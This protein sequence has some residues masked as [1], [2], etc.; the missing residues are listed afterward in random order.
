MTEQ[1]QRR[2]DAARWLALCHKRADANPHTYPSDAAADLAAEAR[3]EGAE[4]ERV[5]SAG[6]DI[7]AFQHAAAVLRD[8]WARAAVESVA[9]CIDALSDPKCTHPWADCPGKE[10]YRRQ[11]AAILKVPW[12]SGEEGEGCD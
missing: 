2:A 12:P 1:E 9:A 6:E 11:A 4:A 8:G 5:R 7:S 3:V 10:H